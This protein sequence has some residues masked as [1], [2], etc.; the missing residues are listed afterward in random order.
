ML[1]LAVT[2]G[3]TDDLDLGSKEKKCQLFW[4]ASL[5]KLVVLKEGKGCKLEC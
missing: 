1:V 5:I 4:P 2:A 3:T